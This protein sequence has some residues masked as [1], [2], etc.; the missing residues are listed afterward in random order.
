MDSEGLREQIDWYKANFASIFAKHESYKWV[1]IQTFQ[2]SYL[3]DKDNYPSILKECF[4]KSENLLNSRSVFSLGMMLDITRFSQVHPELNPVG[5]DLFY[6]LFEGISPEDSRA[7]LLEKISSFRQQIRS[8]VRTYLPEKKNDY[9]DLHA[10]SVYLNHRY[11]ETFYMYRTWE[12]TQFNKLVGNEF[13]YRW[14][15]DENYLAY[16]DMCDQL[17]AILRREMELDEGFRLAV[18]HALHSDPKYYPDPEYRILTQDFIFSVI[19]YR[20]MDMTGRYDEQMKSKNLNPEIE[21]VA[22]EDLTAFGH[23]PICAPSSNA[24]S[25]MDYVARQKENSRLGKAGERWVLECE[26][27]RLKAAGRNDLAKK[28]DWVANEDDSKGYDILSFDED[29]TEFYIEVKT[30]NY[31]INTPFYISAFEL[32]FSHENPEKYRLYRVYDF[33]TS[34]KIRIISGDVG[35]LNPQPTN[36]VVY[37]D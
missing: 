24:P 20:D 4:R 37:T 17:N 9:Q 26:K 21:R 29:G 35:V 33:L 32:A 18:E 1:S 30:T 28:V 14:G 7:A 25:K 22:V 2:S 31:G 6:N 3:P 15:S 34:A 23:H 27:K 36:Y 12:F 16:M 11:P 8:Y 5:L 13:P 19:S 10:V